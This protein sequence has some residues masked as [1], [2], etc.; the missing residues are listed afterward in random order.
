MKTSTWIKITLSLVL[1][2]MVTTCNLTH[3]NHDYVSKNIIGD[4]LTEKP[5][6]P[7]GDPNL[8]ELNSII[9]EAIKLNFYKLSKEDIFS[10]NVL[11]R[12]LA[13][14]HRESVT[15]RII[16]ASEKNNLA[17]QELIYNLIDNKN[18]TKLKDM[19]AQYPDTAEAISMSI[20]AQQMVERYEK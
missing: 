10:A 8:N 1:L 5:T 18:L 16:Q 7:I 3:K 12:A 2:A 17:V 15:Y 14:N 6:A 19:L 20:K 13:S 9:I 4:R 11:I